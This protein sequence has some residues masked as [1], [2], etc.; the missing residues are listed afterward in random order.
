MVL[1]Y[2]GV[3]SHTHLDFGKTL[4]G[5]QSVFRR[6]HRL[7]GHPLFT[8]LGYLHEVVLRGGA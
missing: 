1:E 3:L 8:V 5:V 4:K 7:L 6:R 2:P